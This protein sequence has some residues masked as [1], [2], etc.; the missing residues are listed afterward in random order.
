MSLGVLS[1]QK[2]ISTPFFNTIWIFGILTQNQHGIRLSFLSLPKLAVRQII[3]TSLVELLDL[4]AE[5]LKLQKW[6]DLKYILDM[7]IRH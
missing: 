3:F 1:V 6:I 5:D 2:F 4:K 7:T